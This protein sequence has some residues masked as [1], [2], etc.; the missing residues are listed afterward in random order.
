MEYLSHKKP[1]P[2]NRTVIV[3]GLG[4]RGWQ[5]R[6]FRIEGFWIEVLRIDSLGLRG[7]SLKIGGLRVEG[8]TP[9]QQGNCRG[10]GVCVVVCVCVYVCAA[11]P[12]PLE[13]QVEQRAARDAAAAPHLEQKDGDSASRCPIC[14]SEMEPE[15]RRFSHAHGSVWGFQGCP[16]LQE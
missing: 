10:R 15:V 14:R 6:E 1:P 4:L 3:Q 12:L 8:L 9:W 11:R 16:S 5:E 7:L 13:Q 2:P